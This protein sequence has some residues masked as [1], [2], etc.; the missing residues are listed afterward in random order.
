MIQV[1]SNATFSLSVSGAAPLSYQWLRNGIPL[2]TANSSSL[3]FTA[4]NRAAAGSYAVVVTN[5]YGSITSSPALLRV[6][7]PQ[8][9]LAPER[10]ADGR[11]QLRFGDQDGGMV[12][13][14]D[15]AGFEVY[16]TT[17][18]F[19]TNAWVRLTNSLTLTNGLLRLEDSD[20]PFLP[21]RFYRVIER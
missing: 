11:L 2:P 8:R 17:N 19:A 15:A 5:A 18:F 6:L 13:A 7:V 12:G 20:A 1:G 14:G 3:S 21:R 10:L 4:T 16:A 9:L